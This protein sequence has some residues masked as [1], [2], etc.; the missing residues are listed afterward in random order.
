MMRTK[1][2]N[3][4]ITSKKIII[5]SLEMVLLVSMNLFPI[6]SY[7]QTKSNVDI[8]II[9]NSEED[10]KQLKSLI[11]N[12]LYTSKFISINLDRSFIGINVRS[13]ISRIERNNNS[14]SYLNQIQIIQIS[15]RNH[16]TVIEL[17]GMYNNIGVKITVKIHDIKRYEIKVIN[18]LNSKT[19]FDYSGYFR[20]NDQIGLESSTSSN[21]RYHRLNLYEVYDTYKDTNDPFLN[22][23]T[24]PKSNSRIILKLRD[25]SKLEVLE[26]NYGEKGKWVRVRV[27]DKNEFG[28]V[29]RRYVRKIN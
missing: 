25:G 13:I 11:G 19:L 21:D 29:H 1:S 14:K 23:R 15:E 12:E 10:I 18:M 22:L 7:S 26:G 16:P 6:I 20:L 2:E 4:T 8:E 5:L 9:E 28:Y 24:N 3:S 27:I 17:K